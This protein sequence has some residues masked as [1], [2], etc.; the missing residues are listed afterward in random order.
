M[1]IGIISDTHDNVAATRVAMDRFDE[2]GVDTAIHCGDF[3]APPLIPE[4]DRDG[5]DVHAVRGNNDG[6]REGLAAAFESLDG[7][8]LHGRFA[9]LE[10][11]GRRFAVLHGEEKPVVD[12]LASC[13][14]Y[15]YV[16]YGHWHRREERSVGDAL[17]VNPGAQFPTVPRE[18]RT[19]AIVDTDSDTVE[20]LEIETSV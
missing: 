18:H 12:A 10:F 13:G 19:V 4:L 7:G 2:R 3:V 6:E 5:I 14:E 1:Q 16:C 20:F 11:D 8:R 15:D 17:V 9:E